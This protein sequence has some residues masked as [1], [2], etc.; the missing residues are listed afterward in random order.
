[1]PIKNFMVVRKKN[2][3]ANYIKNIK[4]ARLS[5]NLILNFLS[6]EY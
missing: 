2:I 4:H 5:R 1:M 3:C 6:K